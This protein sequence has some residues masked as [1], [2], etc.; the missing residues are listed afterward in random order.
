LVLPRNFSA[1][2]G[3]D[4]VPGSCKALYKGSA[5]F[6]FVATV[7]ANIY[8]L[9]LGAEYEAFFRF[10]PIPMLP[11]AS[12]EHGSSTN[13]QTITVDAMLQAMARASCTDVA[14]VC[15]GLKQDVGVG[16]WQ[17]PVMAFHSSDHAWVEQMLNKASY[18]TL[19][20]G[21]K[22]G[23]DGCAISVSRPGTNNRGLRLFR[24][25]E[26]LQTITDTMAL[27]RAHP[28]DPVA[29]GLPAKPWRS[30]TLTA[31]GTFLGTLGG[32]FSV[33]AGSTSKLG[34][35]WYLNGLKGWENLD[36][37][38]THESGVASVNIYN[39]DTR[40][41][42]K[43]SETQ[44]HFNPMGSKRSGN[45]TPAL[46]AAGQVGHPPP[47]GPQEV[48]EAVGRH[49]EDLQRDHD[50]LL[51]VAGALRRF[52]QGQC[53]GLRLEARIVSLN[54]SVYTCARAFRDGCCANAA[55]ADTSR[56]HIRVNSRVPK[57][58][59]DGLVAASIR[60]ANTK[61]GNPDNYARMLRGVI[62]QM[63]QWEMC[64]EGSLMYL[65]NGSAIQETLLPFLTAGFQAALE[66]ALMPPPQQ[67]PALRRSGA[68]QQRHSIQEW[69][70]RTV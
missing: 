62:S 33:A 1:S 14:V 2:V 19:D 21:A 3:G 6:Q 51:I 27:L 15:Y 49:N 64:H 10:L 52:P 37:T 54:P 59:H 36:S 20:V 35:T 46:P 50:S 55:M 9:L 41:G 8:M 34:H 65:S 32:S 60:W 26:P 42:C 25:Y 38:R 16:N 18:F 63:G 22:W 47:W 23:E 5:R 69:Y 45:V 57:E 11:A 40:H 53:G 43:A 61:K 66:A 13:R 48:Q 58:T 30:G 4:A 67:L 68:I 31:Y 24:V 7:N 56:S 39:N 70:D 44:R 12:H 17:A 29:S 28:D